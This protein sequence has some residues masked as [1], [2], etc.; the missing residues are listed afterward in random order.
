MSSHS[1]RKLIAETSIEAFAQ[2]VNAA[3]LLEL[4]EHHN[5]LKHKAQDSKDDQWIFLIQGYYPLVLEAIEA[6]EKTLEPDEH[7]DVL[8]M[9]LTAFKTKFLACGFGLIKQSEHA[10]ESLNLEQLDEVFEIL[11][12][13]CHKKA[14]SSE[15]SD[16]EELRS[17]DLYFQAWRFE[18]GIALFNILDGA[19]H[20]ALIVPAVV[21]SPLAFLYYLPRLTSTYLEQNPERAALIKTCKS[22]VSA[23]E[24]NL[25]Q[26]NT[27][28]ATLD[29][30]LLN[31]QLDHLIDTLEP[32]ET[33]DANVQ[34][35]IRET[36]KL[37]KWLATE[38]EAG[39]L[40]KDNVA[41]RVQRWKRH[42]A[43]LHIQGRP[44][45]SDAFQLANIFLMALISGISIAS[46]YVWSNI[47]KIKDGISALPYLHE[48]AETRQ[49]FNKTLAE[50]T[51]ALRDHYRFYKR[52]DSIE[53]KSPESAKPELPKGKSS[54]PDKAS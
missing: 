25:N 54:S 35:A 53:D 32:H 11:M 45:F 22:L 51:Q 26:V 24:L 7:S 9:Q 52:G 29:L 8:K 30:T 36:K 40:S 50:D 31:Q 5:T 18:L 2:H 28:E 12:D 34:V 27:K 42:E 16:N 19:L 49:T 10:S 23:P 6:L 13:A 17:L 41:R 43:I 14:G 33:Q 3:F 20:L 37:Q 44:H 38:N 1:E 21:L 47:D 39:N 4:R 48:K 46:H 15:F